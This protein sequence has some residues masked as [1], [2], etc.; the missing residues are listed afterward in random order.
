VEAR[1]RQLT[2][3]GI[4]KYGGQLCIVE[5]GSILSIFFLK[6][7]IDHLNS[8]DPDLLY[9]VFLFVVF[10]IGRLAAVVARGY[11]DLHVYNY[12]RFVQT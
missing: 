4:I 12:F 11:Y 2:I 8:P 7:I 9:G 10:T 5:M 1:I 6:L 3:N